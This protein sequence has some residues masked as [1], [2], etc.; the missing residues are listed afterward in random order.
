MDW[1]ELVALGIVAVTAAVFVWQWRARRHRP[2]CGCAGH[3]PSGPPP[4]TIWRARRGERPQLLIKQDKE[5]PLR[6]TT[7]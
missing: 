6:K 2:A 7:T 3:S 5:R 1:Q 4:T